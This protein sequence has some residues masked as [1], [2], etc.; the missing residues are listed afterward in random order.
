M[1]TARETPAVLETVR[2]TV[3]GEGLLAR[4]DRVL[5]AVSGGPDSVALLHALTRLA[6]EY[7]LRLVVC[8]VHHG[9]RPEA[10]HDARFVR[11]LAAALGW[12]VV[13]ERVRV[14]Q[15]PDRSPEAAARAARYAALRRAADA[16]EA[17]RIAVGH[18]ADDQ[19]ETVLMRALEG[20]GPRGLAGI[21][22]RRGRLIRPLLDV[23]RAAILAFL[24][25][26]GVAWLE[27]P[28][29]R[30]PKIL[31]N[32]IRH[33]VLPLLEAH[34]WPRL[35]PALRR[36]ARA[37]RETVT[38]LDAVLAPRAAGLARPG[39]GGVSLDLAAFAGL[40]PGGVKAL[41]RRV[42]AELAEGG[43]VA[44]G[45]RAAHFDQLAALF[46]ARPGARV[47]L[48]GGLVVER[49]RDGL[50][51]TRTHPPAGPAGP[52]CLVV[53]GETP[54]AAAGLR[55]LADLGPRGPAAPPSSPWTAWFDAGGVV[56]AL[57]VRARRP[58]DR[59]TPFGG[60]RPVRVT[61]L[62]AEAGVP[63]GARARWP[64]LVAGDGDAE[65]VLWVIGVRRSEGAPVTAQTQTVLRL[66][67]LPDRSDLSR[68][69]TP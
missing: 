68:E 64:L 42:L 47:R 35:R 58:G 17:T 66:R 60:D 56:G 38:A 3:A 16:T 21:P 36:T 40:P 19:A 31:R 20:A 23:P 8:H 5:V 22:V 18:T 9:L 4:G 57:R 10:D 43:P 7:E 63:R 34:G 37:A 41:L 15:R 49:A 25:A 1:A 11:E 30:D 6:P 44:A 48:P 61:R 50:W 45:L 24:V 51:V 65:R 52:T 59:L 54:L 67:A 69:D 53:P 33:E 14:P 28:S 62:L 55:L 32:R 26:E 2:A 27:D 39:P 46:A 13:V 12:P 29:N